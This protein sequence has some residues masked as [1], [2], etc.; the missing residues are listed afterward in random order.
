MCSVKVAILIA[1]L[2]QVK[3]FVLYPLHYNQEVQMRKYR[4]FSRL[5]QQGL[6]FANLPLLG[7]GTSSHSYCP[8]A[9]DA[10]VKYVA[11]RASC[12]IYITETFCWF[13]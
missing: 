10:H 8:E 11:H 9:P 3:T 2:L 5:W 7:S 4:C 13:S 1:V 12:L 6:N